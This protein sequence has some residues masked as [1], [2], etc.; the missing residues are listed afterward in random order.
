M[1]IRDSLVGDLVV[2]TD[3]DA[4]PDTKWLSNWRIIAD[5]RTDFSLFGGKIYPIWPEDLP[6][7]IPRLVNLGAT[8]AIT[9]N[10]LFT[11]PAPAAQLW[12]P[13]MA[14]RADIF[15]SGYRF[16]ENIG[17]QAG[18]YIMGSEVEFS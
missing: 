14:I 10:N 18:Q 11:G 13:N 1:C 17:P 9:P 16:N 12:G 2:L 15:A 5:E 8:Y 4:I 7:W 6:D 3:D